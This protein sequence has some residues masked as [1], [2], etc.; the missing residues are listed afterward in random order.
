MTKFTPDP[1]HAY[2]TQIVQRLRTHANPA[3]ADE[4][5]APDARTEASSAEGAAIPIDYRAARARACLRR[6]GSLQRGIAPRPRQDERPAWMRALLTNL[7]AMDPA[8]FE[9]LCQRLLREAGFSSVEV[10]RRGAD[11]GVD[12]AAILRVNLLSFHVLFQCKRWSSPVGSAVVRDF[13]GAVIGRADKG[14]IITTSTF[15]TEARREAMREGAP[16]VDLVDGETLGELLRQHRIGVIVRMIE[17][18]SVD[19]SA[20]AAI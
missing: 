17:D 12:G 8:A 9:R 2:V 16:L 5:P 1:S 19:E 4:A 6:A 18:V 7:R 11:G 3:D 14:I 15:T 13:R 10:A 20:L